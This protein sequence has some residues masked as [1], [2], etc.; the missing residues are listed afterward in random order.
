MT[1]RVN[2]V[3]PNAFLK[4]LIY[5]LEQV[6]AST[7]HLAKESNIQFGSLNHVLCSLAISNHLLHNSIGITLSDSRQQIL[8]FKLIEDMSLGTQIL[9]VS[10]IRLEKLGS[11]HFGRAAA[12]AIVARG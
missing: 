9:D 3:Y 12:L 1:F 6:L 5:L 8:L 10:L 11:R 2:F 4:P 7:V